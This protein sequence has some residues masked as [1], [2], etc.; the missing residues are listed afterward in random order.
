MKTL[1]IGIILSKEVNLMSHD[2]WYAMPAGVDQWQAFIMY[3]LSR[4]FPEIPKYIAGIELSQLEPVVGDADGLVYLL[5]GMAAIPIIIRQNKLA[6]LDI[7]VNKKQEFYPVNETFLQKIYADNVIG[8]PSNDPYFNDDLNADGPGQ[9][10]QYYNTLDGRSRSQKIASEIHFANI[11]DSIPE[12]PKCANECIDTIQALS[13]DDK[14]YL[15]GELEKSAALLTFF[16]T[17]HPEVIHTLASA[18]EPKVEKKAAIEE[19]IPDL[20]YLYKKNDNYYFNGKEITTKL[21]SEYMN[22][23]EMD[24]DARVKLMNGA[25]FC[26]DFRP[27]TAALCTNHSLL[28]KTASEYFD[29]NSIIVATVL[30]VSG[31][32]HRGILVSESRF[33]ESIH[34]KGRIPPK[35]TYIFICAEGYAVQDNVYVIEA[36]PVT[37]QELFEAVV[38]TH[39]QVGMFGIV[40][41]TD[42]AR[43]SIT[44][45]FSIMSVLHYGDK[46]SIKSMAYNMLEKDIELNSKSHF[47]EVV[48]KKLEL[49]PNKDEALKVQTGINIS[50]GVNGEGKIVLA[51][52]ALDY[53]DAIYNL[54]NDYNLGY[55]DAKEV[56][57][58]TLQTGNTVAK[59]AAAEKKEQ[60]TQPIDDNPEVPGIQQNV[61]RQ[62]M[63]PVTQQD[64]TDISAV[65]SPSL[66]DAYITGRLTD[67]NTAGREEIMQASDTIINAIKAV[68]KI[69]FLVR[70]G[71]IDYVK[72]AD[73]QLALNKLSDVAKSLGIA[74]MQVQ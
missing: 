29:V 25:D 4:K 60:P 41:M 24:N 5:G 55:N 17:N 27:K 43:G 62:N 49:I 48:D 28:N 6:P 61:N 33:N 64:L 34:N 57:D 63:L 7:M 36:I 59:I 45:P 54:M 32:L 42:G 13:Y 15:L 47:C 12:M 16:N 39:P 30:D 20:Q 11:D 18:E 3:N 52:E 14:K 40:I 9:R 69:L 50:L 46:I 21:A 71:K 2:N 35:D 23:C 68:G 19:T 31:A 10:V 72:E 74:S 56:A 73:A 65:N 44:E 8:E 53:P 37:V 22:A 70:V 1:K 66:M 58:E 26:L 51:S 67:V 38:P